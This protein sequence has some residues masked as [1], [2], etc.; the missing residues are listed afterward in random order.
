MVK[1]S[2]EVIG[3]ILRL[4]KCKVHKS[5]IGR[6]LRISRDSVHTYI[7]REKSRLKKVYKY[8][9]RYARRKGYGDWNSYAE[10]LALRRGFDSRY[11]SDN[12]FSKQKQFEDS[13]QTYGILS[14]LEHEGIFEEGYNE[15]EV[16]VYKALDKL[17]EIRVGITKGS[18]LRKIIEKRYFQDKFQRNV[19]DEIGVTNARIG[20]IEKKALSEL[21]RIILAEARMDD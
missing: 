6:I 21:K 13:M 19:G 14:P 17:G 7:K 12:G 9:D 16:D 20:Q 3:E 8:R 1:L 11:E 4:D 2:D 15:F 5:E 18:K 10:F